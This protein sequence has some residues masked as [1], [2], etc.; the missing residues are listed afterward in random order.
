MPLSRLAIIVMAKYPSPGKVKTRLMGA[1]T[2]QQAAD[3]HALF[4]RH[5]CSRLARL[6]PA[7]LVVC[8][9]PAEKRDAMRSVIDLP[10]VTFLE[11]CAGDLGARLAAASDAL[12]AQHERL[13]FL[14][15]DSPDLPLAHL[16]KAAEL[17]E[18]APV[19]LSPTIDGGYWSLGL[20]RGVD[21]ARLLHGIPWST[22]QEAAATLR[23]AEVLGLTSVT[24]MAWDDVDHPPDLRRLLER[25]SRSEVGADRELLSNLGDVLPVGWIS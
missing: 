9:D 11:Q 15:V 8:F 10:H 7:E 23:S 5:V 24:G 19:S 4:L 25:L 13:L 1:L 20:G 22:G 12:F 6:N 14:G 16:F 18:L 17:T 21:V 3:V 2:A